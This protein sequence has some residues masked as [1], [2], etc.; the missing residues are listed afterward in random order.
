M[1]ADPVILRKSQIIEQCLRRIHEEFGSSASIVQLSQAAQDS[2]LLN[3][4]RAYQ[5]SI[6]M[7]MRLTR[8]HNLG[9]PLDARDSFELLFKQKILS[10]DQ[11]KAMSSMVGFRNTAVH[12]YQGLN[13]KIVDVVVK[14]K[15]DDFR[16]FVGIAIKSSQN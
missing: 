7:A 3:L 14:T 2:V 6:D 12:D 11:F 9:I 4:E 16:T 10:E 5:A 15:L 13:L 1:A 8:I